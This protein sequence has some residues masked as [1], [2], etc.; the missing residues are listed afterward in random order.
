[1]IHKPKTVISGSFRK[2]L[3]Q[4][5]QLKICLEARGLEVLSPVGSRATNP[6][7]EFILLDEDPF[8]DH[9]TLQ[10]SVFAK[11]RQSTFLVVANVEGYIGRAAT[12]EMGYAL[13]V[14]IQVFTVEEVSDPNLSCYCRPL[15]SL[16]EGI[17][18]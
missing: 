14:G 11:I 2:H 9:R 8:C 12:L 15:R 16:F 17:R 6:E 1:M 7:D 3:A 18:E 4:I 5:Y 10:D 13:S